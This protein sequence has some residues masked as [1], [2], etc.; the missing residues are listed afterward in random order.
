MSA[1]W[2]TWT[3]VLPVAMGVAV[4]MVVAGTLIGQFHRQQGNGRLGRGAMGQE[5]DER[6]NEQREGD[7]QRDQT[8]RRLPSPAMA[9]LFAHVLPSLD[10]AISPRGG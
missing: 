1:H 4:I 9:G 2:A 3:I 10:V 5:D 6:G 7:R 8:P